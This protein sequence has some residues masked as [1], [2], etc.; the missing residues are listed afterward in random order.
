MNINVKLFAYARDIYGNDAIELA[1]PER[2]DIGVLRK[3]LASEIPGLAH[4]MP[5]LLFAV[6]SD[7]ASDRTPLSSGDEVACIPPVSGG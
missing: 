2:A 1:L 5:Q 4:L 7:Y 3:H 6:N